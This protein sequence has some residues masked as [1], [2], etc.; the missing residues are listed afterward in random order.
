M[1]GCSSL[2]GSVCDADSDGP[3]PLVDDLGDGP[4]PLVDDLEYNRRIATRRHIAPE[5]DGDDVHAVILATIVR[6][7]RQKAAEA[8][9]AEEAANQVTP[10][11]PVLSVEQML[12]NVATSR[13]EAESQATDDIIV[14]DYVEMYM[15]AARAAWE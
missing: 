6:I 8:R 4:P 5:E 9:D 14:A 10:E 3:P 1:A 11:H 7:M 2:Y 15:E 13:A 12:A